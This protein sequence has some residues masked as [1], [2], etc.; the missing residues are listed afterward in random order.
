MEMYTFQTLTMDI[1]SNP[2]HVLLTSKQNYFWVRGKLKNNE[3]QGKM[4]RVKGLHTSIYSS[5]PQAIH[6]SIY[7]KI[8]NISVDLTDC[9]YDL[10]K[11]IWI[12]ITKDYTATT[13]HM[14]PLPLNVVVSV[15]YISDQK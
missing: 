13:D 14:V 7:S 15:H 1:K 10:Y 2:N 4:E 11:G 12:L 9:V 3:S 5:T 8:Q 6:P